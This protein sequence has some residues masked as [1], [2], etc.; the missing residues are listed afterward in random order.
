MNNAKFWTQFD[1]INYGLGEP[2]HT[3]VLCRI[4]K[5]LRPRNQ[6]TCCCAPIINYKHNYASVKVNEMYWESP[7]ASQTFK[8]LREIML[9]RLTMIWTTQPIHLFFVGYLNPCLQ[10]INV[11]VVF[12]PAITYKHNYANVKVNEMYWKNPIGPE[13]SRTFKV[14]R[15]MPDTNFHL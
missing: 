2:N 8:M 10:G 15:E 4:P 11:R 14:L 1:K 5:P 7:E 13:A 12:A 3:L 9:T 6:C